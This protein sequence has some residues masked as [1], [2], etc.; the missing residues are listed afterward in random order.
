MVFKVAVFASGRGSDFQALLDAAR[1]G[2]INVTFVGMVTDNPN[3]LAIERARLAGVPCFVLEPSRYATRLEYDEAV[4]E[5]MEV[6]KPDLIVLAGYMRIIKNTGVLENYKGK[7]IN[8]H[9]SLLPKY[10][11]AHAQKDAFE[12]KEKTSGYTIHFVDQS[13]DGGA[14]IY[15]EEVDISECKSADDVSAKILEREHIGLPMVVGW[16]SKGKVKLGKDG[17]VTIL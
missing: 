12:A 7:I 1:L 9:P 2:R 3:A 15:Q 13:L 6:L 11:G 16:F 8:I 4:F 10:P 5:K 17:K 14:I